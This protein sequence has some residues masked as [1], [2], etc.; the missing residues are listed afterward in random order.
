MCGLSLSLLVTLNSH[1]AALFKKKTSRMKNNFAQANTNVKNMP[2]NQ[3]FQH[4]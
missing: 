2:N 4:I 3:F 1:K